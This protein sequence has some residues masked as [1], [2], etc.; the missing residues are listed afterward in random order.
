MCNY[1]PSEVIAVAI[2]ELEDFR[3][4][5]LASTEKVMDSNGVHNGNA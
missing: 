2:Y 3:E 1:F 5:R 4:Q